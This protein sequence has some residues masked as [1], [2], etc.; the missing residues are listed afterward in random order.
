[1]QNLD[2]GQIP[3][4]PA[5]GTPHPD[6]VNFEKI[7]VLQSPLDPEIPIDSVREVADDGK[8]YTQGVV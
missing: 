8:Y 5:Y 6:S 7:M 2:C 4:T 1:V 3:E